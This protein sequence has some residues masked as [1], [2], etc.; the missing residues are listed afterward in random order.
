MLS[1]IIPTLNAEK[2]LP[3]TLAALMDALVAGMIKEVIIVD[4]GSS[5]R[6]K[7][8][9]EEAGA[10]LIELGTPSRGGQQRS[11]AERAK[12]DWLLFLHADTELEPGWHN[13]VSDFINAHMAQNPSLPLTKNHSVAAFRFALKESGGGPALLTGLVRLRNRL[14]HLPYGDQGLLI[15]KSIYQQAGGHKPIPIMEDVDLLQRLKV[16]PARLKSRAFTSADRF[17]KDGYIKRSLR[18]L[19]CLTAFYFGTPPEKIKTWYETGKQA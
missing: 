16:K 7:T 2:T 18:N 10:S 4:G 1:V 15:S 9:A 12:A 14:L 17:R 6:T 13:E 19:A 3:A 5:D 8:I 11:G